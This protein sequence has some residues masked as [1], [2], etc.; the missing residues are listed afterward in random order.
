[1]KRQKEHLLNLEDAKKDLEISFRKK[2]KEMV[3]ELKHIY[4][5]L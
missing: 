4:H 3:S 5:I 2:A 1:V